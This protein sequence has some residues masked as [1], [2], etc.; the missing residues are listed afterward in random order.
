MKEAS[1]R[2]ILK[3]RTLQ[4]EYVSA[5]RKASNSNEKH[6]DTRLF[7]SSDLLH[8]F[9]LAANYPNA[10][11]KLLDTTFKSMK[12]LLNANAIAAGDGMN[13]VRVFMIQAQVVVS[14]SST[15]DGGSNNAT[16]AIAK[17]RSSKDLNVT[18]SS[19]RA[20]VSTGNGFTSNTNSNVESSTSSSWF[21]GYFSSSS[22]SSNPSNNAS[23]TNSVTTKT[24]VSSSHGNAGSGRLNGKDLEKIA[25]DILSCLL[26]LLELK[27]LPV[28]DE[29]WTQSVTLC[30]LLYL[31][32]R[33]NVRQAAHSTLPQVLSL[34]FRNDNSLQLRVKT[35]DDLLS[36]ALGNFST[37]TMGDGETMHNNNNSHQMK[38]KS[39]VSYFQGVFGHCRPGEW[40]A[41]QPPSQSLALELMTTLLKESPDL[42]TVV[43]QKTFGVVVQILQNQSRIQSKAIPIEFSEALRLALIILQTQGLEWP[44]ECRELIERLAQPISLATEAL[45]KQ[46][47]FED[48][49]IYNVPNKPIQLNKTSPSSSSKKKI[50]TLDGLPPTV[51]WKAAL[52]IETIKTFIEETQSRK[53]LWLHEDVASLLFES[54]SDFCTIGASC[55]NHM[56]MLIS[57]CIVQHEN[58][59]L[60][61]SAETL[62]N[63]RRW[64]IGKFNND[65]YILGDALWVAFD[66]LLLMIGQLDR[67][68]LD[69]IFAPS[70]SVIQHYLKRFPACDKIVDK[71][72]E[73]Y[74]L[75]AKVSMSSKLL[76][77]AL[78]SSLCK[79][80][81]PQWGRKD[82][83]SMLK[84]NNIA[85]LICLLNIAHH[86][87][88]QIGT[89]WSII[90]QTFEELS[91][92]AIASPDLSN[93]AY[94]GALSISAAFA[95]FA[96]FSTCLSEKSLLQY[97]AA[98]KEVSLT[99]KPPSIIPSARGNAKK[100]DKANNRSQ[101]ERETRGIG[102]KLMHIGARAIAW[103]SDDDAIQEDVPVA[104]R[105]SNT[106]YD[107]YQIDFENRLAS[108]RYPIRNSKLPYSVALLADVA[109][110]NVFR[111]SRSGS[112]IFR[113]FCA[114][115]SEFP[116]FRPLVLDLMVMLIISHV[117]DEV[118]I[119]APFFG[120]AK[121][122]HLE[123]R[124]NE[125]LAV[126]NLILNTSKVEVL[127]TDLI[128]P[129]C[130]CTINSNS[131]SNTEANLEAL[132][133]VLENTGHKL[134][135]ECWTLIVDSIASVPSLVHKSDDWTTACQIGFRCLKL[136]IDDFLDVA[137][138]SARAALLDCC[139]TFGSSRQDMNTSLTAIGLL[140][141]IAEQDS[142]TKSVDQALAKLVLL[143]SDSRA[144]VRNCSV[145]TL[146]S[147]IVSRAPK[148]S[149]NQWESCICTTIFG[150]YDTVTSKTGNNDNESNEK[151]SNSKSRYLVNIHHSRDS[152]DKQWVA[153]QAI[154]LKGLCRLLR[155][156][157][158]PLLDTT[159][160]ISRSTIRGDEETPWFDKAW[161][162]ILGWAYNAAIQSGGR[163][164]LELRKSG[165]ELLVLCNQLACVSGIQAAMTPAKVG[166][167]ME[168]INGALRSV[169]NPEKPDDQYIPRK[170]RSSRAEMWRENLFLD[171]FDVLE[172]FRDHI[173]CQSSKVEESPHIEPTQN[174]VLTKIAVELSRLYECCRND[175]FKEDV[176]LSNFSTYGNF[177]VPVFTPQG[178]DD[179]LITRFV[180]IIVCIATQSS[181]IPGALFLSQA[182]RSC[183]DLLKK[184]A[185][186]GS[187]EAFLNLTVLSETA[188]YSQKEAN[189][190]C[191]R[192]VDILSH[193]SSNAIVSEYNSEALSDTC[194]TLVLTRLLS[195]FLSKSNILI[196]MNEENTVG[197]SYKF[198]LPVM[199]GGLESA[200]RLERESKKSSKRSTLD[201]LNNLWERVC[202]TLSRML[203]PIVSG[204]RR[205]DILFASDLAVFVN[206]AATNATSMYSSDLCAIFFSGASKSL[207]IAKMDET[208]SET[209]ENFL[210][211]FASC[212]SGMCKINPDDKSM[213][214]IAEQVLLSAIQSLKSDPTE[215]DLN[216]KATLKICDILQKAKTPVEDTVIALSTQL[217]QLVC[218]EERSIRRAAGA[219]LAKTNF[220]R[221]LIDA[222]NRA[223][224]AEESARKAGEKASNLEKEMATLRRIA[225]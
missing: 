113:Q 123:P 209:I 157:F 149:Q 48:G 182:Q 78:L 112:E 25:L 205:I 119:P 46:A 13:M 21:G 184:M 139:S 24:A 169:G 133:S 178:E 150:V 34:L 7:R 91:V 192:G 81:L 181:G 87:Y 147:C 185:S 88:D 155:N 4:N 154:V 107:D 136:I 14:Y 74:S 188:F 125:L 130:E 58:T 3:L 75:L 218:V 199:K 144:E 171:A 200:K 69:Q 173:E 71:S 10:S 146:F 186:N 117:L 175:E 170:I 213:H 164:T 118:D 108:S 47:D 225:K 54:I 179:P 143:S 158:D 201:L 152:A 138:I 2:A 95:R 161:N 121:I 19:S 89:D 42:F 59:S 83:S 36:C 206:S 153:T 191:K 72:L 52:S 57:S 166:T 8:P 1:E 60:S 5:V 142:G 104:N 203:T 217:S 11:P 99:E 12:L 183:I 86:Y 9:L 211:L 37:A 20:I 197:F 106:F 126:E 85:S 111:Q 129:L 26:Q 148:F 64:Q 189:G 141:K 115:S 100:L 6:P 215:I 202:L 196:K 116:T 135:N 53:Q 18:Q 190:A 127:Q 132:Y 208:R 207:E 114:V 105:T 84:D 33:Q 43:G 29:Q 39:Y 223:K 165:V 63:I 61:Y 174:Q 131:S 195:L 120:P 93:N 219:V 16:A 168:V 30:C 82:V 23:T 128:G 32:M 198:L 22:S 65:T 221:I 222:R 102:G 109:M 162:T 160:S 27:D 94:T 66:A 17:A 41:A 44:A 68:V 49:Y 145:N 204:S 159:D 137:A 79:L 140:W 122:I 210:D 163:E 55:K 96:S 28:S 40:D 50:V 214:G 172:S 224:S 177:L 134:E 56:N 180:R 45:R 220:K 216:V 92:L 31:P 167:N 70:L 90:I 193:E 176:T 73:G 103:N 77:G 76:R 97:V 35:W 15:K 212:F 101:D 124:Q 110:S 51:L 80:S 38:R 194:K 187:P 156:F 98:L 62:E 67:T 151:L